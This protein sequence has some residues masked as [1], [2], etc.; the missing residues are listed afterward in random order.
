MTYIITIILVYLFNK[1]IPAIKILESIIRCIIYCVTIILFSYRA[2][3]TNI[4]LLSISMRI[5]ID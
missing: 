5:F 1:Q 3:I 2:Y 4:Y